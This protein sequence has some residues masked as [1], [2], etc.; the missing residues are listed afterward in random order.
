MNAKLESGATTRPVTRQTFDDVLVPTYAPAAM[1]P[2]RASGLDL[3]DQN[4]KHYLDFTSGI[5]VSSLGH[6]N[7]ILVDA[8]TRQLNTVWHLGNGYTNEPVLR[9][10]LALTEATFAD[11]AFFCN[12]GAEANEGALKLARKYAHEKFG[13]HKSR[14]ISCLS[15]FHGRTLFTV[16]VGGQPKYTEGFEPLPQEI[17][18]VPYNDIEAA[19]AAIGDDVCAVIVEPIQGEGGVIPGDL[20][21]L[22]ALREFCNKSGALLIFDEVQSGVGRTGALYAYMNTGVTPDILT[23]AKALGNG[24]PI[25]AM[26]TTH[27]IAAHFGVGSH[28]TTY[29]GNP[30]AATVALNVVETINQP[31][32]LARVNEASAKIF[33]CLRQLAADY[34]QVFGAV[35]GSGLLIGLP[36][37][38]GFAGRAKDITKAAEAMGLMLLIAGPDVVRFAPALIVTD[39]QID[40]AMRILRS[41]VDGMLN[42]APAK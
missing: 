22:K 21:Y 33:A 10:G 30:L 3:W 40:E 35:R 36:V 11:R 37:A 9:L 20:A 1:V 6:C 29:G 4:G 5:A 18:H 26:L 19:R 15:S 34:P 42:A 27:E 25:G 17:N 12:S 38:E 23:S 13:P 24:Y 2:V 41:A 16:S 7:P 28:G 32:F 8:L 14:I 39:A 31:A